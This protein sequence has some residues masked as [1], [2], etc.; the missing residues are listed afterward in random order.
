MV[1]TQ[2]TDMI[3]LLSPFSISLSLPPLLSLHQMCMCLTL[4]R[5][6]FCVQIGYACLFEKSNTGKIIEDSNDS[7]DEEVRVRKIR[8]AEARA[9]HT[10]A[11][12]SFK[13]AHKKAHGFFPGKLALQTMTD[14][15]PS[16]R[17]KDLVNSAGFA[18]LKHL[19]ACRYTSKVS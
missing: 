12:T 3:V 16:V 5:P 2:A 17:P 11:G 9:A 14:P 15:G 13:P 10:E 18:M 8:Q 19:N 7:D 6:L 4:S 1:T